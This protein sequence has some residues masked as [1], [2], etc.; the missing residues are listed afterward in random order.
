[1]CGRYCKIRW[2][3]GSYAWDIGRLVLVEYFQFAFA[4]IENIVFGCYEGGCLVIRFLEKKQASSAL[5]CRTQSHLN[6]KTALSE[7]WFG[8]STSAPL[9][10]VLPLAP[11][12]PL[13]LRNPPQGGQQR[14]LGRWLLSWDIVSRWEGTGE[15]VVGVIESG[16]RVVVPMLPTASLPLLQLR[17]NSTELRKQEFLQEGG[18]GA[19]KQATSRSAGKKPKEGWLDEKEE[20]VLFRRIDGRW[21]WVIG[22]KG[23]WRDVSVITRDLY[24]EFFPVERCDVS[25]SYM[26]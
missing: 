5:Q 4:A 2:I 17:P 19:A 9:R 8:V 13:F 25:Y 14:V 6:C 22:W 23:W 1:M 24:D 18:L 7:G 3:A 16:V 15:G 21:L 26:D 11:P 12:L 20:G 10:P